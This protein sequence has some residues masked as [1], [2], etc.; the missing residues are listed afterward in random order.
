[1]LLTV[2]IG[3]IAIAVLTNDLLLQTWGLLRY[4]V[5]NHGSTPILP[6]PIAPIPISQIFHFAVFQFANYHFKKILNYFTFSQFVKFG[7]WE[8]GNLVTLLK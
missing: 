8:T 4:A 1:M 7:N 5:A 6:N 2:H 3:D